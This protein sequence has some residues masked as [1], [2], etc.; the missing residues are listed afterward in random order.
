MTINH[1]NSP[2]YKEPDYYNMDNT[3]SRFIIKK[4]KTIQQATE[5]SCGACSVLMI[6]KHFGIDKYTEK[7]LS[8]Y[9]HTD[10]T[11]GTSLKSIIKLF[12][13]LNFEVVSSLDYPKFESYKQFRKFILRMIKKNIPILV[14][15]V[16]WGGHWRIIIGIDVMDK[17][18]TLDDTLIFADS[19]NTHNHN[20]DGY[21]IEN[22]EKFFSMFFDYNKLPEE[23]REQPWIIVYPK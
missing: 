18:S 6:L 20:Q 8:K 11:K 5:T 4:F 16:D 23:E 7:Q 17:K 10:S 14:E 3:D 21:C 9:L 22:G 2:Y 13:K 15:N 19:Y 1:P 12:K